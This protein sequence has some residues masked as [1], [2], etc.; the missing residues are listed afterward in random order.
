MPKKLVEKLSENIQDK[1]NSETEIKTKYDR[2]V[3]RYN[4]L[5]S[6]LTNRE[7]NI[8][9]ALKTIEDFE[10]LVRLSSI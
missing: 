4:E 10:N 2:L 5:T 8:S 9:D 7:E 3:I 6:R 1:K